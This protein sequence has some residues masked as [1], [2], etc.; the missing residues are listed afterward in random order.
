[1]EFLR[2]Y[3]AIH[4]QLPHFP[5]DPEKAVMD[6]SKFVGWL[7]SLVAVENRVTPVPYRD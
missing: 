4:W 7:A 3:G 6:V 1:M 2:H 5:P